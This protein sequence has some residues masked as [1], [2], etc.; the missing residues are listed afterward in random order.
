MLKKQ[1]NLDEE[2]TIH[3]ISPIGKSFVSYA[4]DIHNLSSKCFKI[5]TLLQRKFI[6]I[7]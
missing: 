7:T 4:R 2:I 5:N 3:P 1:F 6:K